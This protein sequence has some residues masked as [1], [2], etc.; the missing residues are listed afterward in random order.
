MNRIRCVV[1]HITFQSPETGY[2]ILKVNV[3][4]YPDLVTVVGNLKRDTYSVFLK[5]CTQILYSVL[6]TKRRIRQSTQIMDCFIHIS[7]P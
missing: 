5:I 2:S 7:S 3:K 6:R 1:E 4:N